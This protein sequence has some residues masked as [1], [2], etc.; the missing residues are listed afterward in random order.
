VL[1][2]Y[3][4]SHKKIPKEEIKFID[5]LHEVNLSSGRIVQIMVEL[6]GSKANVSYD[7][8]TVSNYTVTLA[9]EKFK[10]IPQMLDYFEELKKQDPHF[11]YKFKLGQ[12]SRVER[13]F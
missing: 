12:F 7:A 6:Y 1:K 10:D 4:R 9:K 13:I 11:F 8:K 3:L 2:K 5:L